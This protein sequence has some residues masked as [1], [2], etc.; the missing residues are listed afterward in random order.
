MRITKE[1]DYALRIMRCLA[2]CP[3]GVRD[4]KTMSALLNIPAR[5]TLKI[6]HKLM[7]GKLVK[8][9]KGVNGGYKVNFP[10]SE[11]TM[12]QIVEIIDGPLAISRCLDMKYECSHMAQDKSGCYFHK[13]FEEINVKLAAELD[14]ITLEMALRNEK[15]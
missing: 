14:K 5:F 11:I 7:I 6:L 1:A 15:C 8:S 13:V 3:D 10:P 2:E 4:A 12:R 9:F